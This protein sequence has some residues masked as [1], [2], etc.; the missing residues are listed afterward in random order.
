MQ[1]Q[2]AQHNPQIHRSRPTYPPAARNVPIW[3][4]VAS[5]CSSS[6]IRRTTTPLPCRSMTISARSR[7]VIIKT[8]MSNV[9]RA[10][11][12]VFI[13]CANALVGSCEKLHALFVQPCRCVNSALHATLL[14][15][16]NNILKMPSRRCLLG[17]QSQVHTPVHFAM[18]YTAFIAIPPAITV[19]SRLLI[20]IL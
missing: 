10:V 16:K 4:P 20:D 11:C 7:H 19:P 12:N 6:V 9:R 3:E 2:F 1:I 5:T 14:S 8:Q 13:S 17:A 15:G 18:K